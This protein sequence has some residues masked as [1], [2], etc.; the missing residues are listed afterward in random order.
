MTDEYASIIKRD[1]NRARTMDT[2]DSISLQ[3]LHAHRD[4]YTQASRDITLT[5]REQLAMTAS[6]R[7]IQLALDVINARMKGREAV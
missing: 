1:P 2:Q 5:K 4:A 6:G 7:A 3:V